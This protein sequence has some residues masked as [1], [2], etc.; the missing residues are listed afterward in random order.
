MNTCTARLYVVSVSILLT[1]LLLHSRSTPTIFPRCPHTDIEYLVTSMDRVY[2]NLALARYEV[3]A[4]VLDEVIRRHPYYSVAGVLR[5]RLLLAEGKNASVRDIIR[6]V[7]NTD[8]RNA[9]ALR[10]LAL[11]YEQEGNYAA[12]IAILDLVVSRNEDLVRAYLDRGRMYSRLGLFEEAYAD[13]SRIEH[14]T[15]DE[16]LL[17]MSRRVTTL[18]D[19]GVFA[20]RQN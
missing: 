4:A 14:M 15:R 12:S 10:L 18:I 7:L 16:S 5:A 6:N 2:E 9:E 1:V 20:E 11:V 19:R 8:S 13:L 3:A 17:H